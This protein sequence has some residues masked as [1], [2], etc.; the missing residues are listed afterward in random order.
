MRVSSL[1]VHEYLRRLGWA[2]LAGIALMLGA[3]LHGAGQLAQWQEL[4]ALQTRSDEVGEQLAQVRRGERQPAA[5]SVDPLQGLQQQLPA[6]PEA[7]EAIKRLYR[8]AR[9]EKI[10]LSRGEYA[11]GVDPD[12]QLAR[13]QILLPLR[14]SYLQIRRFL[15]ALLAQMP[16]LV[17]EDIDL[18]RKRIG[19]SELTGRIRMTLYLSRS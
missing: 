9:D 7:T 19:D 18:Q 10:S 4:H 15:Q 12:T 17:L 3:A 2:A 11:L 6:Q 14:G 13:Y 8:L 5:A 16:A 1:H